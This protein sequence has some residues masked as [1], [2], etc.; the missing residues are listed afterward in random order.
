ML[1]GA[2]CLGVLI[3]TPRISEEIPGSLIAVIVGILMVKLLPLQ[4]NTIGDLYTIS[5][6]LPAFRLPS[7]SFGM[8]QAAL[9]DA[10]TIAVLAAIESLRV[11]RGGRRHDQPSAPFQYRAGGPGRRKY[12]LS[13]V[14]RFRPPGAIARTAANVKNGGRTPVAGMVHAA[15]LMLILL[16]L[17]PYAGMIP[18]PTIAAILFCG[19]LQHVPVAH[20]CGAGQNCAQE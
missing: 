19:G 3:L 7:F 18:M 2:V 4:V 13:P 12:C 5:S 11:L 16:I 20:L 17:M 10:F 9:P 6:G 15:V 8:I 14:R 1:V